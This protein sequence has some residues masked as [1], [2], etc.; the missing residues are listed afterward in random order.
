MTM[1]EQPQQQPTFTTMP[2]QKVA[3][4]ISKAEKLLLPV[5][6]VIAILYD[7]LSFGYVPFWD[8]S[9]VFEFFGIFWLCYLAL[10]Y[11]YFWKKLARNRVSWYVA[12]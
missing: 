5:A 1:N 4:E 2:Q 9:K 7:R 8:S 12:G 3:R 11:L 6:L 10:F